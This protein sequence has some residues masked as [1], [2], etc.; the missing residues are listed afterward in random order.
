MILK[1]KCANFIL[2]TLCLAWLLVN[3]SAAAA[4]GSGNPFNG[5]APEK[6]LRPMKLRVLHDLEFGKMI[7]DATLGGTFT[8]EPATGKRTATRVNH[9]GGLFGRAEFELTGEPNARFRVTLPNKLVVP[10]KA[11][12]PVKLTNFAV[13]PDAEGTFGP[14]GKARF[15]VGAT[16]N[17]G[18]GQST[19]EGRQPID[20]FIDYLP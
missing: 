7:P 17:F 2:V 8:L 11:G 12:H 14:D 10:N 13:Y 3:P 1:P 9:L 15:F 6:Q 18:P 16:L 4:Q 20:I 5:S 19:L